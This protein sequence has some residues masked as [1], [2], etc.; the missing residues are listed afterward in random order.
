MRGIIDLG[1]QPAGTVEVRISLWQ[2]GLWYSG[3][4]ACSLDTARYDEWVERM[5]SGAAETLTVEDTRVEGQ[6]NAPRDG[7][8]F[9]SIPCDS[10]WR[11]YI[12]GEPVKASAVA[13]AFI[14]VPGFG[15]RAY[16][17][18]RIHPAR[19]ARRSGGVDDYS[20]WNVHSRSD[21]QEK[22]DHWLSK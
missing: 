2:D 7:V 11:V 8:L 3:L 17:P 16:I 15:R 14:A 5:H 13:G 10:G 18:A 21:S 22:E 20:A 4:C 9:T 12:D 1:E 19:P 6:V